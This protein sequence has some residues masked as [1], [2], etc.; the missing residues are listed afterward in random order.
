L[1]KVLPCGL[2]IYIGKMYY[3]TIQHRKGNVGATVVAITVFC[4]VSAEAT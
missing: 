1:N 3:V 4:V 2:E